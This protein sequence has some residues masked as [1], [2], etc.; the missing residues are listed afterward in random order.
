MRDKDIRNK[1]GKFLFDIGV[2]NNVLSVFDNNGSP[3]SKKH[4]EIAA[5]KSC[6]VTPWAKA[7]IGTHGMYHITEYEQQDYEWHIFT[8]YF[9]AACTFLG[10]PFTTSL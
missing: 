1:A 2:T 3:C 8:I 7:A 5:K 6:K 10:R 9:N 4:Q